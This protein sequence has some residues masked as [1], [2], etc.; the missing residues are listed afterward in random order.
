MT[1]GLGDPETERACLDPAVAYAGLKHASARFRSPVPRS[2]M[3]RRGRMVRCRRSRPTGGMTRGYDGV[4]CSVFL[5]NRYQDP[6]TGVFISV[7][8]LIATTGEP[9]LYGSGNPTTLSDPSGLE[10]GCGATSFSSSSCRNAYQATSN[11]CILASGCGG[12]SL[13]DSI[14]DTKD[15]LGGA[16]FAAV[17]GADVNGDLDGNWGE[18]SIAAAAAG[19]DP[20]TSALLAMGVPEDQLAVVAFVATSVAKRLQ[21]HRDAYEQIDKDVQHGL[22]RWWADHGSTVITVASVVVAVVASCRHGWRVSCWGRNDSRCLRVNVCRSRRGR[23][24]CGDRDGRC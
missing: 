6:S 5:N 8:P 11:A 17:E 13:V 3:A 18:K 7:D 2:G 14:H 21:G 24:V 22:G 16:V 1:V 9:Y 10:P 19:G 15:G 12:Q 4:G 20:L 23:H